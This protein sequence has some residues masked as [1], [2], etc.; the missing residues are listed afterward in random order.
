MSIDEVRQMYG[1]PPIGVEMSDIL[2]IW[3]ADLDNGHRRPDTA[4]TE[5]RSEYLALCGAW[6]FSDQFA[7]RP[8]GSPTENTIDPTCEECILLDFAMKAD[9]SAAEV[10]DDSDDATYQHP[11]RWPSQSRTGGLK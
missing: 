3:V 7:W 9:E 1:L 2:H 11:I 4:A 6:A 10:E 5:F 8:Y